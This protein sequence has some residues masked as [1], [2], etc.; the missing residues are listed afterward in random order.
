MDNPDAAERVRARIYDQAKNLGDFAIGRPGKVAGT[1]EK[2]LSPLPYFLV[3]NI[4]QR[5]NGREAVEIA[6][7][8]HMARNW[9]E[10]EPP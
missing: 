10:G 5:A 1:H 8:I 6:D 4:V 7:I 9:P 3:Y 2:L